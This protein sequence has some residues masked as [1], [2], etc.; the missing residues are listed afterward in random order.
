MPQNCS[1]DFNLMV[2]HIDTVLTSGTE[3]EIYSLK[4]K[5][6]LQDLAHK[7]DFARYDGTRNA[8]EKG[9]S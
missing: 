7:D 6:G 8:L 4:E 1:R 3:D 9:E 5:F 2:D